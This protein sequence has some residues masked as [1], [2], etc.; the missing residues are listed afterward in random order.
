[1]VEP[2]TTKVT[3]SNKELSLS[4]QVLL[5]LI[6]KS[7]STGEELVAA[8][9]HLKARNGTLLSTLRNEQ[10]RLFFGDYLHEQ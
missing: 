8:T 4:T 3:R 10:V 6:L 5:S 9:T 7:K 1:M 2:R